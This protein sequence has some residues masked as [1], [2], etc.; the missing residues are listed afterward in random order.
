MA[1]AVVC[2]DLHLYYGDT[3][4]DAVDTFIER[5]DTNPPDLL[6]LGGDIWEMWRRDL[7]GVALES[8]RLN[9]LLY[10][11]TERGVEIAY[12]VGNHDEWMLRHTSRDYDYPI[13]PRITYEF[14]MDGVDYWV[15][16]GHIYEY[17]YAGLV[18]DTL[19]TSDDNLGRTYWETWEERPRPPGARVASQAF[20][21]SLGPAAS[22]LDPT[23]IR[24]QPARI[25]EVER[26]VLRAKGDAYGLY[27]H[28]HTP[29][30]NDEQRVANWGSMAGTLQT[31][32]EIEDGTVRLVDLGGVT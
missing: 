10:D 31:Y 20:V 30:V 32:L 12:T 2:G 4:R 21:L 27:G 7:F 18:N 16:H 17:A 23:A 15:T 3:N 28:T 22:Y 11:L 29:F 13:T 6:V 24:Q 9:A 14:R 19:A 26:G 5:L 1:R 25:D 8:A